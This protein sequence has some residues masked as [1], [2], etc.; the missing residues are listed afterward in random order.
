MRVWF[1]ILFTLLPG[2]IKQDPLF[3]YLQNVL[4]FEYLTPYTLVR[5][6]VSSAIRFECLQ[7]V[8]KFASKRTEVRFNMYRSSLQYV[9]DKWLESPENKAF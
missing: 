9:P 8:P 3:S 1:L 4:K 5:I 6:E 2:S 7:N